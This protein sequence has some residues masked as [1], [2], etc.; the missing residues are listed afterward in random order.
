MT[1]FSVRGSLDEE[2]EG[3]EEDSKEDEEG[4]PGK[5]ATRKLRDGMEEADGD[6]AE[7]R[8]AASFV[9][10]ADGDVAREIA[11]ERGEFVV[12]PES[13]FSAVAP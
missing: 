11:A 1:E 3:E 5:A 6:D 4:A 2:V 13:E 12:D 8:F 7:T 10:G 9:E